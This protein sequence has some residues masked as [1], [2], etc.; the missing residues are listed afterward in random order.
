MKLINTFLRVFFLITL[1]HFGLFA[2]PANKNQTHTKTQPNGKTI[3]YISNG[4][5]FIVWLNSIDGYT[6]FEDAKGEIFYAIKDENEKLVQSNVLASD[7]QYRSADEILFLSSIKKGIFYNSSQLDVFKKRREE[8]YS[9][10]TVNY[11]PSTSTPNFLVIMVSFS[12]IAFNTTNGVTM[13]NQISQANY[14]TN[15]ATG[16]VKDYYFDNSMGALDA[17]F[18]VVGPYILSENQAYYGAET[19]SGGHDIRPREMVEEACSL[20][21]QQINFADFDNDGDG[22]VDMVHVVYAGRGHHN[23]GG[24][25]AIWPHSWVVPSAPTFNGV[26][27]YS[28]S[29][30]NELKT[31]TQVDGIGT[32]CHEM[33][34][35]L[36]LPD[37]Y[38]TDYEGTGGQS[39]VLGSWDLMSSGNYNNESR[40]PPHLSSLERQMLGW[41]NPTILTIDSTIC[42]LPA[43][44]DSNKAYKVNLSYNEFLIFEHRDKTKWD[45]YTPAKGMIIF[46]GDNYLIDQWTNSRINKI[47]INP[48]NRGFFIL[49]AYGDSSNVS[50]GSTTYPG[51]QNITSFVGSKLK[52]QTPTGKALV[53]I[54]YDQD[55]ILNFIYYNNTFAPVLTIL[56]ITN[57]TQSSATLNA[58]VTANSITSMGFEYRKL[59][60]SNYTQELVSTN[61]LHHNISNLLPNTTY[62][63]RVFLNSSTGLSYSQIESF[64]T[65][66]GI[67]LN[68]PFSEDFDTPLTCWN[69]ISSG[70]NNFDTVSIGNL[71]TCSPHSGTNMLKFNSYNAASNEWTA[72]I[73]PKISFPNYFYNVSFW[74]YRTNGSYSKSDEGVEVY[75]NSS[76]SFNGA[77]KIGFI[78]NN[79]LADPVVSS[80]SWNEYSFNVGPEAVGETYIMLK[81]VSKKGY[82]I[83]IDD[84]SVNL[85]Q[86][87]SP[88]VRTDSITNIT[89]NSATINSSFYQGTETII[90]NGMEYKKTTSNNWTSIPQQSTTSPFTIT[91]SSLNQN[92]L[93]NVRPYVLTSSGKSYPQTV[94]TFMTQILTQAEVVTGASTLNNPSS[95]T[96]YGAYSSGSYPVITSGFKYKPTTTNLWTTITQTNNNPTFNNN[97]NNLV[98]NTNYQYRAFIT[99]AI[100]TTFGTIMTFSTPNAPLTLG[101]VTSLNPE[102][103]SET[104]SIIM[105]GKLIHTG[106]TTQNIEIGFI[107]SNSPNPELNQPETTKQ[108]IPY[109]ITT[110]DFSYKIQSP[111]QEENSF[112]YRAYIK[113]PIGI[114]YGDDINVQCL[115]LNPIEQNPIK[116]NLYPNPT[117]SSSKLEIDNVEGNIE[118]T[119]TDISGREIQRM[120]TRANS[121]FE[122][123]IDLRNHSKGIYFISIVT[124]KTKRTEKLILK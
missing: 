36:G 119:M 20:A 60:T 74:I 63:Y 103:I 14:T 32:I 51:N 122:T 50:S 114:Y 54:H 67:I 78:S 95:V 90:A 70:V 104:D 21:S 13:A 35:V 92:T 8:R 7:P 41:F 24:T 105:Q 81:A 82:N 1:F 64:T 42:T 121:K 53:N 100:G 18:V 75:V 30:S 102:I 49:P 27:V 97:L 117:S 87:L 16:S 22:Y 23:G 44:S 11:T 6:M 68:P 47:N 29:C 25:D 2:A 93:Y 76:I 61:P 113:N 4:D 120:S 26:S 106:N 72:L 12:D 34:H 3:S 59:R 85:L 10:R 19:E 9:N 28:Y 5:E 83:Y 31:E 116:I 79:R 124:D 118:I 55:T 66:C 48:N 17:N 80:N 88:I 98:A 56:P 39:I 40:T 38:D 62:Q 123:T 43:L 107:Y 77:R 94:D 71:P 112:Y 15:G 73:T 89:H 45:A 69:N 108:T 101:E 46:H 65:D 96:V 33:G 58:I 37:F 115:Q 84:L 57:S 99:N 110:T 91:L 52:D 86:F 109:T 111:C